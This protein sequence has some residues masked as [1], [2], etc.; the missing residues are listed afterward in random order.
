VT[1]SLL[2]PPRV[3]RDGRAIEFDTR[4]AIALLA[5]LILE[6]RTQSRDR[7]ATMLWPEADQD[8]ARASL[9]RTL[10]PVRTALGEE[11]VKTDTLRV[12]IAQGTLSVDVDRFRELVRA[13][14]LEDA[15]SLYRGDFLVGFSLKDSPE[16]EDW[17]S[18]RQSELRD[19]LR[20]A[21]AR[22]A[23][24]ATTVAGRARAISYA[25][26]MVELDPLD[27]IAHQMLIRLYAASGDRAA[28]MR[29]YGECVRLLDAEL[30]VAPMP[31]TKEL[32]ER[33]RLGET[34][35]EH[36][37]R[38]AEE[39]AADV[40]TLHG[41]YEKAIASYEAAI[42]DAPADARPHIEHKLAEVHHRRGNWE[43]A[44][45]HYR[46]ASEGGDDG[47]KARALADWS[48]AAHRHG[49]PSR[50][51]TFARRALALSE[52][53][54]EVGALAQAHNIL[55]IL[56][57]D[58]R[59][60]ERALELSRALPD[61]SVRVAVLNNLALAHVRSGQLDRALT[62]ARDAL[63]QSEALGD[64]HRQAALHNNLADVLQA[65]GLR[66]EAMRHLKRSAALFSEIGGAREPEVWKLVQW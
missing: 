56:T 45:T 8:R 35:I 24:D 64:R 3:E 16:F 13:G 33:I 17:H 21:L 32:Y 30:G 15:V 58:Q 48:L 38:S 18:A 26:R 55:G 31:G 53:S 20:G 59:H 7:L 12:E 65:L 51:I 42:A 50:A 44:E 28:A 34:G 5:Y 39:A 62:Y 2:G 19:E 36:A 10:S 46:R 54:G 14:K 61:P 41:S 57:Q 47:H 9:R 1:V 43:A 29:Q 66:E 37:R 23:S 49:D 11:V 63:D 52:R 22:L 40:Y 6:G 27:E 4:K 60:F 25:R